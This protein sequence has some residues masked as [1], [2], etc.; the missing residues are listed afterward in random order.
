[1]YTNLS[2]LFVFHREWKE[3]V[4]VQ[5]YDDTDTIKYRKKDT[6]YFKKELSGPGLTGEEFIVMPDPFIMVIQI[7]RNKINPSLEYRKS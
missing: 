2:S 5:D 7:S 6:F 1:M 3:K 4:E